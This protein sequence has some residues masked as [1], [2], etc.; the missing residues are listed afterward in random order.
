M[1]KNLL[2]II[3]ILIIFVSCNNNSNISEE[4]VDSTGK[5]EIKFQFEKHEFGKLIQGEK[6]S[7]N[8]KFT[9]VGGGNLIIENVQTS[10]GCTVSEYTE[11]PVPSGK[12]GKVKITFNSAGKLGKQHKRI[13]IKTN[14]EEPETELVIT[15]KIVKNK[16]H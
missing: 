13:T 6:V 2:F 3:S 8:F 9:N 5:P 1:K 16:K 4:F 7:Y 15:A 14:T 12:S 11:K 10:C